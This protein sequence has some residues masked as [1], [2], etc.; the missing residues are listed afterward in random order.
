M[1]LSKALTFLNKESSSKN[2]R[3]LVMNVISEVLNE[4]KFKLSSELGGALII[5]ALLE[6]VSSKVILKIKKQD[7]DSFWQG[8][9]STLLLACGKHYPDEVMTELLEF[10]PSNTPPHFF[11]IKTIADFAQK[12]RKFIFKK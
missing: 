10:F 5:M 3:V 1:L 4:V 8:S 6:I 7:V 9:A 2:H 12:Y 11:V